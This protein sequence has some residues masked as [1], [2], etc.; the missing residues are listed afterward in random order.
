MI[1]AAETIPHKRL[2]VALV[3]LVK[4]WFLKGVTAVF[5]VGG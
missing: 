2:H 4:I 1:L 3:E 5:E